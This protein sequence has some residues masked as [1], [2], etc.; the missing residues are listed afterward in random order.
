MRHS[1][2]VAIHIPLIIILVFALIPL[3]W[4]VL[5]SVDPAAGPTVKIPTRMT[6]E[7]F[8]RTFSGRPLHWT[9][10]SLL[11]AGSTATL[12][13]FLSTMAAY[14]FSRMRFS[15]AS[16][17]LYGLVFLRTV[18][19]SSFMLP[20][21]LIF[22]KLNLVN[23]YLSVILT[24]SVLNIP[25]ALLLLKG[26]YDTIPTVFE[27][28][29]W[30][31][32]CSRWKSIFRIVLPQC[33]PGLAVAWFMTFMFAWG[34]FLIPLILL[35]KIEL[36]PLSV[37]IFTTYGEFGVVNYGLL[38]SMSLLYAIPPILMYILIQKNLVKGMVG[39]VKG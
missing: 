8:G 18:P 23:T 13:L 7:N 31:D 2:T 35:R 26:F 19:V 17:L 30:I 32:G 21:Y 24:L 36:M 25:F 1:E 15:G 10:N 28:A 9:L 29:S 16:I 6:I 37:G 27:E 4:L 12:V 3:S 38:S 22:I 5:A 34:E 20:I 14:P 11:I 39:Y 33:G